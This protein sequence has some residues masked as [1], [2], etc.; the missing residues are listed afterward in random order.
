MHRLQP[1]RLTTEPLETLVRREGGLVL[2]T[3]IRTVGDFDIAEDAVQDAVVEA[4][5][6]WPERGVPDKP[7]AWLTTVARRRAFDRVRRDAQRNDKERLA[8]TSLLGGDEPPGDGAS[9]MVRDDVLR[10]IFTCCHPALSAEAQVALT[11]RTI[12]GL[13][14]REIAGVFLVPEATMAQRLSR[15]KKKIAVARIPYR[16]PEDHELTDRLR[17]VTA[18]IYAAF[19][20]GHHAPAGE[21]VL[22]VDVA[23][24]AIRL[25]RLVAELV[26]DEPE[27][28]G[29]LALLLA[30]HA[31]R[32][33]RVNADGDVVLLADQDRSLWDHEAIREASQL[34]D[35]ALRRRKPGPY[36]VQAAISC[37]HGLAPTQDETDWRQILELY[38]L[39]IGMQPTPAVG[40]NRAVA[41]AEVHG[42]SA[43]LDALEA[44]GG[45]EDWHLYWAAR[46]DMLRRLG[47]NAEAAAAYRRA[48]TCD[49]ND[50]DRRFLD[51]R[52]AQ[53]DGNGAVRP[54]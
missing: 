29:L 37:L 36:Q 25:A 22:R 42:A 53:L 32:A 10:L 1:G 12:C 49:C 18:V 9:S 28:R 40:V 7:G 11:L 46:A 5:Q 4:L 20:A 16:V 23:E 31:R 54:R 26:V 35:T 13:S 21:S 24:E 2:A 15:A 38:D 33:A 47:Q 50:A 34:V 44:V 6:V 17:S 8:A 48:L 30:T 3:L 43:G 19:T 27:A 52:L 14:A 41:V 51:A 45:V 39:L